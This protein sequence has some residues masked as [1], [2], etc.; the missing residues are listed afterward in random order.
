MCIRMGCARQSRRGAR[1]YNRSPAYVSLALRLLRPAELLVNAIGD[2][3]L[4]KARVRWFALAQSG[5]SWT[6]KDNR[7]RVLL[8]TE[9]EPTGTFNAQPYSMPSCFWICS[10]GT[11]FVSGTV[12]FTQMSCRTIMPEKNEKT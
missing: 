5:I 8:L 9:N 11:P 3:D 12:V 6:K 1:L 10:S 2:G 7:T 4:E